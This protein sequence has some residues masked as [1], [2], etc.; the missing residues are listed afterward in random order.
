MSLG[1]PSLLL[2]EAKAARAIAFAACSRDG[3]W[4]CRAFPRS[5]PCGCSR[6]AG[7]A[8]RS[9]ARPAG[10]ALVVLARNESLVTGDVGAPS[11]TFAG[12]RVRG[13]KRF[14]PFGAQADALLVETTSGVVLVPRPASGWNAK[15]MPTIDH[16][17]RFAEVALND[18]GT[19]VCEGQAAARRWARSIAWA[20]SAR[21]PCCSV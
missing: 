16:A 3:A 8:V 20:R 4:R 17:Q 15:P 10:E 18:A 11:T 19:L 2:S 1:Y 13:V 5:S 6:G 7:D 14:V 12:G 21:P 9:G